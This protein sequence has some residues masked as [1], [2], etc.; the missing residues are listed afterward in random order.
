MSDKSTKNDSKGL[1]TKFTKFF[2]KTRVEKMFMKEDQIGA[3]PDFFHHTENSPKRFDIPLEALKYAINTGRKIS[4]TPRMMP[5]MLRT[6]K[7]IYA[8]LDDL[9]KNPAEPKTTIDE[10]LMTELRSYISSTGVGSIGFTKIPE[11]YI[12]QQKGIQYRNAIIL[13]MEMDKKKME[14]APSFVSMKE[15]FRTYHDLGVASIKISRYLRN[16][17]FGTQA[18]HPLGGMIELVPSAIQANIGWVG[19]QGL[20]ISPEFGPRMR[21]AAVL[22]SIENLPFTTVD[23]NPYSWVEEWCKTCR[24]CERACPGNAILENYSKEQNDHRHYI[25]IKKCFP[26]FIEENGCSICIKVCPFSKIGYKKVK[27]AFEKRK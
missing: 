19:H 4:L 20:I 27:E 15:V 17:G 8:S 26:H 14:T 22:T 23:T 5:I 12:F 24:A 2:V 11:D 1:N 18:I 10:K 6:V 3:N 21:L 25:E 9:K 13:T 7:G 16:K